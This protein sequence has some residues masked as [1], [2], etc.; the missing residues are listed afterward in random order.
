[1]EAILEKLADSI[2]A[3]IAVIVVV[4]LFLREQAR[5]QKEYSKQLER[6]VSALDKLTER[7]A[8]L[9]K[10][11]RQRQKTPRKNRNA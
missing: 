8:D 6:V 11:Q 4:V 5:M 2:P 3:T 1:M 9:E 10:G 7:I